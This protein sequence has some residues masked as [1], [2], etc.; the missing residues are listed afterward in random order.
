VNMVNSNHIMWVPLLLAGAGF[1]GEGGVEGVEHLVSMGAMYLTAEMQAKA[2]KA[3]NDL[4]ELR[5]QHARTEALK[6][7]A[8]REVGECL[9]R[10]AE[11]EQEVV[12]TRKQLQNLPPNLHKQRA[13]LSQ[14]LAALQR[15]L[16][17]A[18]TAKSE[19]DVELEE[20]TKLEEQ[21]REEIPRLQQLVDALTGSLGDHARNTALHWSCIWDAHEV[22]G[23][24]LKKGALPQAR[25]NDG[26]TALH[27]A[28]GHGNV[29]CVEAFIENAPKDAVK[30]AI[31][32]VNMR[33][34]RP[35]DLAYDPLCRRALTLAVQG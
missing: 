30:E 7:D 8:A 17:N 13:R 10:I 20:S 16:R 6:S 22:V 25:D 12:M 31:A 33:G 23:L 19:K 26:N 3:A 29:R 35:F 14:D 1:D 21:Q 11:R 15:L 34:Q 24:L 9:E 32:T 27:V 18:R 5:R 28:V 4:V 2:V